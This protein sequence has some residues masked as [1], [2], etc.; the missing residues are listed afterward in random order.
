M[1][2][3]RKLSRSI[4]AAILVL[5]GAVA[6][7]R[8]QVVDSGSSFAGAGRGAITITGSVVCTR[9]G[10]DEV[11]K[12]QP[13]NSHLYQFSHRRGQ[14]VIEISRVDKAAIF[15]SVVQPPRLWVRGENAV[16]DRLD[17]EE[18]LSK[19]MTIVGV[20]HNTRTLDVFDIAIKG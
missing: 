7:A 2:S 3:I 13:Y 9:C 15:D 4:T 5:T 19:E 14:L 20:L 10:L 18:N 8:G 17:A 6:I 11:R 1:A 12:G 16:L